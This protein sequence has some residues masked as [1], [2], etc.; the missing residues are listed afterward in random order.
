MIGQGAPRPPFAGAVRE[1]QGDVLEP[2][3]SGGG[4]EGSSETGAPRP[5]GTSR[6][7]YLVPVLIFVGLSAVFLNRLLT[8]DPSRVPSTLIGRQVPSFVLP[9]L[10]ELRTGGEPVPGLASADLRGTITIVNVWASWCAPCRQEHPALMDLAKEADFKVVG[11]NYKD[12][13]ENARRFLG[14]L[15]NPYAAVGV[16]Q[17]GRTAIELGVYGVP[18]TFVL[19]A[20]GVIRYRHV[21]P[22]L[23]EQVAAFKER[24]KAAR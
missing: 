9:P 12:R 19:G 14:Q 11:I 1:V 7:L 15:G 8:G 16:D 22:I 24:L 21:G 2:A 18:E 20:D 13:P 4:S 3:R 17:G 6:L 5:R 23:P 10:E